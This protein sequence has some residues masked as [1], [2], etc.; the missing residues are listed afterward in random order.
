MSI[1]NNGRI[2]E[3]TS[4]GSDDAPQL[5]F[6][7]PAP[8]TKFMLYVDLLSTSTTRFTIFYKFLPTGFVD[9]NNSKS[10]S[11]HKAV[12]YTEH[13]RNAEINNFVDFTQ[14]GVSAT[15]L[16]T[17]KKIEITANTKT[18]ISI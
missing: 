4:V 5:V 8:N 7:P 3:I 17:E 11:W 1:N 13:A 6:D 16:A 15:V 2:Y 14:I 12:A 9:E 18:A 10:E